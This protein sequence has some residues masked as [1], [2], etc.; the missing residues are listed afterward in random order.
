L[1]SDSNFYRIL[2][3]FHLAGYGLALL[4]LRW[5]TPLLRAWRPVGFLLLANAS[6]LTAW[7]RVMQGKT[8]VVW[9]PS[10]R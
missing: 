6:I 7:M 5:P 8:I 1:A 9:T 4:A 2:A 10:E 3:G